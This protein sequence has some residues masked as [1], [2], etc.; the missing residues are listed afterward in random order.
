MATDDKPKGFDLA[1]LEQDDTA[2]IQLV[3][4]STGDEIGASVTVYGQ[5]SDIFRAETRKAEAKYTEYSRRNRGKF[6]PP[7]MREELDKT[8]VVA[9]VK[10]IDGLAYKGKPMTD[11]AEVFTAFPWI[12]E[13]VVAGIMDR[14][15]FIKG[16][17]LK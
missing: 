4:P 11:P 1:T 9:C 15:N 16:S 17:P 10:S 8:K 5:D 2:V 6:M 13:Q 7:E 3:H 14:A 12:H